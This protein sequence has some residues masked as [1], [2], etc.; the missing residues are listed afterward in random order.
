MRT[1]LKYVSLPALAAALCSCGSQGGKTYLQDNATSGNVSVSVD[2]SY[3][4]FM[5]AEVEG[6]EYSYKD[7]KIRANYKSEGEVM[8]DLMASDS[9]RFAVISRPLTAEEKKY[10][11]SLA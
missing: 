1:L 6:F 7:A 5:E 2:E 8:K 3:R 11:A 10:F 4:P 9:C